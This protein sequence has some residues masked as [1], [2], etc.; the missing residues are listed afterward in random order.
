MPRLRRH[1]CFLISPLGTVPGARLSLPEW[2]EAAC[3]AS[4]GGRG[5]GT[6]GTQ[7][8]PLEGAGPRLDPGN[9]RPHRKTHK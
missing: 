3:D 8:P 7:D 6:R 9:E 1:V 4:L 2:R 5:C